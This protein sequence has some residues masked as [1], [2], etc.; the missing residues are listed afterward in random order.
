MISIRPRDPSDSLATEDSDA[1]IWISETT[2]GGSG[3]IETFM[4]LYAEDPRRFYLLMSA[5]LRPTEHELIDHQLIRF[6]EMIAG[7]APVQDLVTAV[8]AFR[9]VAAMTTAMLR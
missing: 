2:P 5:A 8:Q 7:D 6:L 9:A 3:H 4:R 1:E